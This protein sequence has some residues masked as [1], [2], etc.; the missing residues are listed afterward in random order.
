[1]LEPELES[2]NDAALTTPLN[3]MSFCRSFKMVMDRTAGME[4]IMSLDT[5]RYKP[6]SKQD[7]PNKI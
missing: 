6:Y 7:I 1:L 5:F 2:E 4:S 3:I